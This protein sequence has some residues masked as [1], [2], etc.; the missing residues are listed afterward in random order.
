MAMP[1]GSARVDGERKDVISRLDQNVSGYYPFLTLEPE[2]LHIDNYISWE[3]LHKVV[4]IINPGIRI[5]ADFEV[6]A[7]L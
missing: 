5:L 3:L 4:D 6:A 7:S 2:A 1:Q